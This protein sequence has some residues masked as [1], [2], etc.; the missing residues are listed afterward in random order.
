MPTATVVTQQRAEL[1]GDDVSQN[2]DILA[3]EP[4]ADQRNVARTL[5]G[6]FV[7]LC[8]VGFSEQQAL[9]IVVSTVASAAAGTEPTV[10]DQQ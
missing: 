9:T 7:A 1:I 2:D 6:L 8:H 10:T 5:W 4:T 3:T